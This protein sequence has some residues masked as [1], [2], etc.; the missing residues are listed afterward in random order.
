[1]W[2]LLRNDRFGAYYSVFEGGALMNLGPD[3]ARGPLSIASCY[4]NRV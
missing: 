1:M 3:F 2:G 4:S